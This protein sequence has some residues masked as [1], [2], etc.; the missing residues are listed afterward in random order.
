MAYDA[1]DDEQDQT[2]N[3]FSHGIVRRKAKQ[4]VGRQGFKNDDAEDIQQNLNL[5]LLQN[6][7]SFDSAKGHRNTSSLR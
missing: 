1:N 4:L 5:R 6:L 2:L 3:R 7:P